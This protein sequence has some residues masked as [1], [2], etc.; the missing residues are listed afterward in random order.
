MH[1]QSFPKAIQSRFGI[2]LSIAKEFIGSCLKKEPQQ[3]LSIKKLLCHPFVKEAPSSN[4]IAEIF[5][6][7]SDT[8]SSMSDPVSQTSKKP[9]PSQD[10]GK[11]ESIAPVHKKKSSNVS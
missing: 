3:R 4:A 8:I 7:Q 9:N 11:T 1:L 10:F 5:L 6:K 2:L